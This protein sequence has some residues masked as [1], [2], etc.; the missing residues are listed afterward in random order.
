MHDHFLCKSPNTL[1]RRRCRNN[2]VSTPHL[3]LSADEMFFPE[4]KT[5]IFCSIPRRATELKKTRLVVLNKAPIFFICH[6]IHSH[7]YTQQKAPLRMRGALRPPPPPNV[8]LA[9]LDFPVIKREH[10]ISVCM[11]TRQC[12]KHKRKKKHKKA[13]A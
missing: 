8:C 11:K 6:H 2:N 12:I 5:R 13:Q 10:E 4:P 7:I 3:V 9:F 1:C